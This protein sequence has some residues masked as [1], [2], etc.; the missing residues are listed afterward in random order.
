LPALRPAHIPSADPRA[1][2]LSGVLVVTA[3]MEDLYDWTA[4]FRNPRPLRVEV[5]PGKGIWLERV[6][7]ASPEVNWLGIEY[8]EKRA[9]WIA[10]KIVRAGLTNVRVIWDDAADALATLVAPGLLDAIHVNFPDPWPKRRHQ[11]R[12]LIQPSFCAAMARALAPGGRVELVTDVDQYARDMVRH[13]EQTPGL[14][15]ILGPGGIATQL[16]GYVPSVH[17]EKFAKRGRTFN[18]VR[19]RKASG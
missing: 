17:Y 11:H 16:E 1:P 9:R 12:R 18:F 6:A 5:G 10:Q 4:E 7:T 8:K 19:F 14:E 15:N 13:L 2:E 3:G